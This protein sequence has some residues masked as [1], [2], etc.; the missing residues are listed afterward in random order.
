MIN[1][2]A[3]YLLSRRHLL[4]TV[5][6]AALLACRSP[7]SKETVLRALVSDVLVP[8]SRAATSSSA[9]LELSAAALASKPSAETLTLCRKAW[10]NAL[11]SWKRLYCFRNGPFV[12]TGALFR[13]SFWPVRSQGLEDLLV[14]VQ[15]IDD[16][17]ID[18]LGVDQKGL[19]AIEYLLFGSE[20]VR[21]VLPLFSGPSGARRRDFLLASS[22]NVTALA[23]LGSA[24]LGDGTRFADSFAGAGQ[25]SLNQV[26]NQMVETIEVSYEH[27]TRVLGLD[28]SGML[29]GAEVEGAPS[30]QSHEITRTLLTQTCAL[31]ESEG[32]PRLSA[33]VQARSPIM[34][35]H[36]RTALAKLQNATTTLDSPL[37]Q[38]VRRDRARLESLARA[39]KAL[40]LCFKVELA[41]ALGVTLT[42]S[43]SDGD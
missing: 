13:S 18:N 20:A 29:R 40:E 14:G 26:V 30:A 33:L 3:P 36:V 27:L 8:A 19:Y 41:S 43:R 21:D 10:C 4:A 9:A 16:G 31:Y 37:E 5:T 39:A 23:R 15:P 34:D 12:G 32:R 38:L 35:E 6:S 42:F 22:R 11:L 28:A 25:D 7:V 1:T 2:S 24:G 17:A